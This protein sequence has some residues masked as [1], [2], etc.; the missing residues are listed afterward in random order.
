MFVDTFVRKP[1]RQFCASWR[2]WQQRYVQGDAK[3]KN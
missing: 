3:K 2:G 1:E